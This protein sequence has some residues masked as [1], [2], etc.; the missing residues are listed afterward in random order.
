MTDR[1]NGLYIHQDKDSNETGGDKN[2][3]YVSAISDSSL[4]TFSRYTHEDEIPYTGLYCSKDT[5]TGTGIKW[6]VLYEN[7]CLLR[8]PNKPQYTWLDGML[9]ADFLRNG[10]SPNLNLN[11]STGK[12]YLTDCKAVRGAE[13]RYIVFDGWQDYHTTLCER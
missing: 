4:Y 13:L 2:V 1:E 9:S 7:G 12:Y 11:E 5:K 3:Q 8:D 6:L 10:I